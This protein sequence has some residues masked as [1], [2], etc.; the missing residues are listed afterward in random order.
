M[1]R[2]N[3]SSGKSVRFP[4][5]QEQ[6]VKVLIIAI[7]PLSAPARWFQK[8]DYYE[9]K[10][11]A[12]RVAKEWRKRGASPLINNT[13]EDPSPNTQ[14]ALTAWSRQ[15]MGTPSRRGLENLINREICKERS[16]LRTKVLSS[17]LSA[18]KTMQGYGFEAAM[19]ARELALISEVYSERARQFALQMGFADAIALAEANRQESALDEEASFPASDRSAISSASETSSDCSSATASTDS[20]MF[21]P[22]AVYSSP[23]RQRKPQ[24]RREITLGPIQELGACS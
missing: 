5:D 1:K 3:G 23:L 17:I 6:L 11:C 4:E 18:Q 16:S 21:T 10:A 13:Y 14:E 2:S 22:P 15:Q 12:R 19:Q 7:D 8:D 20:F 9:F 24:E